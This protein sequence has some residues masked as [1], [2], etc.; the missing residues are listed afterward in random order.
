[1][2]PEWARV[3]ALLA[4]LADPRPLRWPLAEYSPLARKELAILDA[5]AQV[6]S[7]YGAQAIGAYVISKANIVSDI[8]ETYVLMKQVGLVHGGDAPRALVKV[9]PLFETITDLVA[10]PEITRTWLKTR[11]ARSL[12]GA[13]QVQEIMVGYSD[14]NKD[15]GYCASRWNVQR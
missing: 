1:S 14:S 13:S 5:A 4:Q 11:P 15:G 12:L 6:V 3:E 9:A 10:A 7:N 8:L 2:L